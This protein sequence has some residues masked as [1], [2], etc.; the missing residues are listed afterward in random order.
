MKEK[1]NI[2]TWKGNKLN[3]FKTLISFLRIIQWY[4]NLIIFLGLV[5]GLE[6]L[7]FENFVV[8]ILG[9]MALCLITSAG[10][11]RND[12]QDLDADKSHPQKNK[13]PLPSGKISIKQAHITF[14]IIFSMGFLLAFF[15]DFWFGILLAILFANTEI[16]SRII[17]N[18]I[19]VDVFSIGINFILR[20]VSGIILINTLISPWIISGVFFVALLLAFMKRKS[21][22]QILQDS[23]KYHRKVLKNYTIKFLN[24]SIIASAI[25]VILTYSIYSI[26]GPF[27]DGRLIITIPFIFF[28]VLRQLH[29]SSINHRLIQANKFFQDKISIIII[30]AYS[31]LT[32]IL[33]YTDLFHNF[34]KFLFR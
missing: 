8:S 26:F 1:K 20:A 13:R 9:F 22:L 2:R 31:I 28:I 14:F 21:E 27:T 6:L 32:I 19:F 24:I 3:N 17:K 18:I 4:K 34:F 12:I 7:S 15:L 5:F 11:I 25:L 29:F 33:L 10:Y 23:A 30:I 16:Y